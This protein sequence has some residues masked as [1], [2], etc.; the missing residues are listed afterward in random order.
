MAALPLIVFD[1]NDLSDV[2]DQ[3]IAQHKGRG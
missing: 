3:L 1:G 2:A